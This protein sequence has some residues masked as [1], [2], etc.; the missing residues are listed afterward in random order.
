MAR[1]ISIGKN[2]SLG[3]P[4][5]VSSGGTDAS[6]VTDFTKILFD[7]N[8]QPLRLLETGYIGWI[9][10]PPYS[11]GVSTLLNSKQYNFNGSYPV[12]FSMGKQDGGDVKTSY[13]QVSNPRDSPPANFRQFGHGMIVTNDGKSYGANFYEQFI[14]AGSTYVPPPVII[15]YAFLKNVA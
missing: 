8:Q 1:R 10:S 2:T 12:T 5:V 7:A 9:T 14:L 11:I 13:I 3:S 4:F 6:S 15:Y